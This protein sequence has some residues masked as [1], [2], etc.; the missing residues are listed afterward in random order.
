MK[1]II[2]LCDYKGNFGYKSTANPYRSGFDKE[3]LARLFERFGYHI[4]F[5]QFSDVVIFDEDWK[6]KLV[7]YTSSEEI[8]G[9]YKQYIEDIVYGLEIMG[10]HVI[11]S[12]RFLKA[13]NNKVFMEILRSSLLHE[14]T[15]LLTS[16]TFGT[17]EELSKAIDESKITFPCVIK[18]AT[19]SQSTAVERA[20]NPK[21]LMKIAKRFSRT[22]H[23]M[24][25]IRDLLLS[26]RLPGYRKES[27]YQ[28]KFI[29][30]TFIP[31]LSNDWKVLIY[32]DQYFVLNRSVR[33]SD[34]RASGSHVDYKSGS[35]SGISVVTLEYLEKIYNQ[36][37]VPF[38]S[39]DVGFDGLTN[40]IFEFQAINFGTTIHNISKDFFTKANN[41]WVLSINNL[42]IEDAYVLGLLKH[43]QKH[44]DWTSD[45][46]V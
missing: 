15:D 41:Q 44:S 5:L 2:F 19:G 28:Q 40:Y 21:N 14:P 36:L 26:I 20:N 42:G 29:V 32:G 23:C 10:A 35:E 34:F 9:N 12:Y 8:G 33:H 27:A 3:L 24:H 7:C 13:H 30:Q 25:E 31:G 45:S 18:K 1:N 22:P 11:P 46:Y 39:I 16:Q 43:L 4:E 6:D 37:D 38:L 17:L